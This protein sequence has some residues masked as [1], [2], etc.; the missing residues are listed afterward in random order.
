MGAPSSPGSHT[1]NRLF[2]ALLIPAL[3]PAQNT[4]CSLSGTVQDSA[5]AL[6]PNAR[7]TLTGEQNGFVRTASTTSEGFFAFPDLTP[8][9][10]T[11]AI[12]ANGFKVYKQTGILINAD[13]HR[14]VGQVK[15]S[16]GQLTE[17][18][19]VAADAVTV[20]TSSGERAGTLSGEQLDQIALRG[21]DV[22]DAISLMPG[23]VDTSDGR[24]APGNS[25]VSNIFVLG[26]RN[27]QKNVTVDGVTNLDTGANNSTSAMPSMDAVAEVRVLMSAYSA[28][29]GRN[30]TSINV[31]TKG[32]GTQVHG[33]AS[34]YVR[35]EAL[36]ANSYFSNAAG[37]SKQE[38]RYNIGSYSIGG[39]AILP[40]I[41][42][43]RQNVFFFFSQEFQNQVVPYPVVQR[44]M[45]TALERQGD[46]SKSYNTN[47]SAINVN[48]PLN[49]KTKF[50]GNLIPASRLTPI[51]KA[52][53]NIFPQPNFVDSNPANR[54]NWNYYAASSAPYNR[55]TETARV[56]WS[57]KTNWQ[58]YLSG[59]NNAD[60]QDVAYNGGNA[61]WIT[62]GMNFPL[63][64]IAM[65]VRA[66]W[67]PYTPPTPSRQRCSMKLPLERV[68][69]TSSL[70]PSTPNNSTGPSWE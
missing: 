27:D 53:L 34:Y 15:L 4:S 42:P 26:G 3:L 21:R 54:F 32:G 37:R 56:D 8:A 31:I 51:G 20:N 49:G 24:D 52:I 65:Q 38:Y 64:P 67:L 69:I 39:P 28:E 60:H 47:G 25:S 46:F 41:L 68:I 13:E 57:P 58:V 35:N 55:R 44:T 16:I 17:S 62:G 36:N 11:I 30:P 22:F 61:G 66:A 10:F 70:R 40:K 33:Q 12:E 29:N 7:V 59:S 48:D 45:P 50:P 14:S 63:S 43:R 2:F 18:I 6:I 9:T 5:G 1:L 19:T 23:V